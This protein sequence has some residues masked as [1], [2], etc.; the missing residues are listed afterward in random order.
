MDSSYLQATAFTLL[1]NLVYTLIT[2]WIVVLTVHLIDRWVFKKI[3]FEEEIKKG[4][5]AA[6]IF[7]SSLFIFVALVAGLSMR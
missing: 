1:I 3:D 4:N 6:A 2:L 5:I 7:V